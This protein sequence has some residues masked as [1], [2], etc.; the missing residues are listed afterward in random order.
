MAHPSGRSG[1]STA[2]STA[3][4]ANSPQRC[5]A[6]RRSGAHNCERMLFLYRPRQTYMPYAL[7]R[8]RSQQGQYNQ[9]LQQRF[10]ASLR[11]KPSMKKRA[12]P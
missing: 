7:P 8:A 4:L 12:L 10:D 9:Q 1:G 11:V 5:E 6:A 3:A 2:S